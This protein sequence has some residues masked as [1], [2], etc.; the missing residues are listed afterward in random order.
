M[1]LN[2]F[3]CVCVFSE[4]V[5]ETLV[6]NIE[7][8]KRIHFQWNRQNLDPEKFKSLWALEAELEPDTNMDEV[9]YNGKVRFSLEKKSDDEEGGLPC[10]MRYSDKNATPDIHVRSEAGGLPRTMMYSDKRPDDI[11]V[12]SEAGELPRTMM[13]SGKRPD[14]IRVRSEAGGLP[15]TMMYSGKRPDDIRV[16]SEAG[17]LPRTMMYSGKRPDDIHIIPRSEDVALPRT[18]RYSGCVHS[19]GCTGKRDGIGEIKYSQ[20]EANE[21]YSV[22]RHRTNT[23]EVPL[24]RTMR[25]SGNKAPWSSFSENIFMNALENQYSQPMMYSDKKQQVPSVPDENILVG[26]AQDESEDIYP[27]TMMYNGPIELV[28]PYENPQ[29]MM[30]SGKKQTIPSVPDERILIKRAQDDSEDKYP[31]TMMYN[32][33]PIE[34]ARPYENPQVMMYS[35]KKQPIP[36]VPDERILIKRAQDESEDIFPR[37]MMYNSRPI[38]L[39]RPYEN[40]QMMMYSDKKQPIPSVPDERILIKRA[41]DESEDIY[42]R[43]MMYNSRPI[44]LARP[45]ENPQM[46]MYSDRKQPI[47]SVPDERILIERAQDESEYVYPR[48]MMYN[49][50]PIELARPYENPQMMMYSDKKQPI[51]SVPDERIL[52]KRAQDES[53]DIYPRMMMYNS[54][55]IELA[56]PYE[57]PQMMMYSDRKQPIPS[58]PDERILIERAQDESEYVYPRTMMYNSRP[59]EL[60]RPYENPQ[61]MMYSDKKQPIS[62]VPDERILIKRAQDKSEAVYPRT[63]MYN[64]RPIELARPYENPQMMMYSDKQPV[65]SVPEE[66]VLIKRVQ[67]EP[68]AQAMMYIDPEPG[69]DPHVSKRISS[70]RLNKLR[71]GSH[72]QPM[73]FSGNSQE[74]SKKALHVVTLKDATSDRKSQKISSDYFTLKNVTQYKYL[75]RDNVEGKT[76]WFKITN[77]L[78]KLIPNDTSDYFHHWKNIISVFS[79]E[80]LSRKKYAQMFPSLCVHDAIK[81]V[82]NTDIYLKLFWPFILENA[83]MIQKLALLGLSGKIVPIEK[84]KLAFFHEL[85]KY[86]TIKIPVAQDKIILSFNHPELVEGLKRAGLLEISKDYVDAGL[87]LYTPEEQSVIENK[88]YAAM[89]LINKTSPE[90]YLAI[91]QLIGSIAFYKAEQPG[92][93]G[94]S[95]SSALGV[96]WED[97]RAYKEFSVPHYAEQIVHEFIHNTLFL[98]DMVKELFVDHRKFLKAKVW[99]PIRHQL[100][101]YDRTFHAC[102]VSTGNQTFLSL[103]VQVYSIC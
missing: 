82:G 50:R 38:E 56:R 87:H 36:S 32:S 42:P 86:Q 46:M 47:P 55:P 3:L 14:D 103:M 59:I 49:S 19:A 58:V 88:V 79:D 72:P 77:S 54:R 21:R 94:G 83:V 6:D 78:I 81:N 16:W 73:L 9:K 75:L 61:M 48:T 39:A 93:A 98:V 67:D 71:E 34:L 7:N 41:Q 22:Q 69:I 84:Q 15:R 66:R 89:D 70:K 13:Y 26:R 30:Y 102:Y 29:M 10:T 52:I 96:I 24:P 64:S 101:S 53:E 76:Q 60:A 23:A 90:L 8:Y 25:Y 92:Y 11:R 33:R 4:V 99:S 37:T 68:E 57:N 18:M 80:T 44:E 20:T 63:M 31:R 5:F 28:R 17:G 27:R 43:M 65:P 85:E 91:T 62:S 100:R 2:F 12:R 51:P 97:P 74:S 40:P 45:Y 35:D 1:F 95:I